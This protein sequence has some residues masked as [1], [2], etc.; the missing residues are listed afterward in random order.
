MTRLIFAPGALAD[1]E[2]LTE[3]LLEND[4]SVAASTAQILIDGLSILKQHALVGRVIESGL[5]EL[6]ISRGR[7]GYVALYRY[8]V[9]SDIALILAIRHQRE[10]GYAHD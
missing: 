6:V 4:A 1:I 9:A 8:D 2:C 3:F 5:R 7:S 10:G